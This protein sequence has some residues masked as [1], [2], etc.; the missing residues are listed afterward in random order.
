[1]TGLATS[2]SLGFCKATNI[3]TSWIMDS[4]SVFVWADKIMVPKDIWDVVIQD[5]MVNGSHAGALGKC[6]KLIFDIAES[7]DLI[8][9]IDV[10]NFADIKKQ[11]KFLTLSGITRMEEKYP[12]KVVIP[13]KNTE[14]YRKDPTVVFIEGN[15]FCL[16]DLVSI[17]MSM[18]LSRIYNAQCLFDARSSLYYKY[19]I[20]I[21]SDFNFRQQPKIEAFNGIFET[22][23]PNDNILP[24]YPIYQI[25]TY[26]K[27][28]ECYLNTKCKDTYLHELEN[29]FKGLLKLRQYDEIQQIKEITDEIMHK[30]IACGDSLDIEEIKQQYGKKEKQ[31]RRRLNYIFPKVHRWSC[32]SMIVSSITGFSGFLTDA[33]LFAISG[34]VMAGA[35]IIADKTLDYYKSKYNWVNFKEKLKYKK[36]I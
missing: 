25:K 19:Y 35:S 17:N 10:V 20:G 24:E 4:P 13:I 15:R 14:E 6:Y 29:N 31:L 12:E 36:D 33:S 21:D 3:N 7:E 34:G 22:Y 5:H 11:L 27:C 28:E 8:D 1:M 23:I 26:E 16:A 18:M 9:K 30:S 32:I 2:K